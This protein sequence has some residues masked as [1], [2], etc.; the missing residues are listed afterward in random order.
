MKHVYVALMSL[1]VSL[2]LAGCSHSADNGAGSIKE[3]RTMVVDTQMVAV[4]LRSP[5]QLRGKVDIAIVP[6]VN[7]TIESVLVHEGDRVEKGQ[8]MFVLNQT[9]YQAAVE[10]AEAGV[11]SAQVAVETQE[12][13]LEAKQQLLDK[14]IISQHEY[15]VQ[16]NR[17][18]MARASLAEAKA[19]LKRAANDL[20]YTVI[21][22]PHTGVVGAINYKQ[23]A[24]VG[25][26]I[27][28]P[29]TIVSDN[30]VVYAYTSVS[31]D[32]YM[33]YIN[34]YGTKEKML[35]SLPDFSLIL[36]K[37]V[38]YS[39][40][41]RMETISG[42]IDQNTGAVSMR[43]A[44]PNPDGILTTGGGGQV[45][46]VF[47]ERAITLPRTAVFGIQDKN[48]VYQLEPA[49]SLYVLRQTIVDVYRLNDTT[50]VVN[51]GLQAGEIVV[52]EGVK[53]LSNGEVVKRD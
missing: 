53:K 41:G 14:N 38:Y 4:P 37:D 26:A 9:A 12:L 23:G 48:Y 45:E 13:E 52:T 44:F 39:H 51:G 8:T 22:A 50:Y 25:P 11:A 6:Q 15:Q 47:D 32:Q 43:I 42:I 49:D 1:V 40:K 24:L 10:N 2:M 33:S 20:N 5:A 46:V 31:G 36:G 18:K 34:L 7:A 35:R 28:Q 19:V 30:S 17:V 27:E 29:M 16:E 21:R 3:V